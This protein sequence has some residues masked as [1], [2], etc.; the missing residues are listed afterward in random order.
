MAFGF[1]DDGVDYTKGVTEKAIEYLMELKTEKLDTE[2]NPD[3]YIEKLNEL[4]VQ[5]YVD[6]GRT[7]YNKALQGIISELERTIPKLDNK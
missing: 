5:G 3:A 4:G 1:K 6:Y 7:N 2:K